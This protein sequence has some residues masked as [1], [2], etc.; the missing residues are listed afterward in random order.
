MDQEFDIYKAAGLIIVNKKLLLEKSGGK[1]TYVV[2]GGRIEIGET[3]QEALMR[4]LLEEFKIATD[5]NNFEFLGSFIVNN[6]KIVGSKV[7][8][9]TY[10]VKEWV[11]SIQMDNEIE[12]IA[13]V[14]SSNSDGLILSPFASDIVLPMLKERYLIS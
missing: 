12:G 8:M 1:D 14:D 2:P 5:L 13:W 3:P 4:E 7:K 10:L 9:E 11:G 6:A